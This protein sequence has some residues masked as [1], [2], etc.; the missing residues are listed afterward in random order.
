MDPRIGILVRGGKPVYYAF[1]HGHGS[2]PFEG[3]LDAVESALG[4]KPTRKPA[5]HHQ[6]VEPT[7]KP[8]AEPQLW[9]VTLRFQYPA[10]DEVGGIV[11]RGIVARSKS[12]ANRIAANRAHGDGHTCGG[13]GRYFFRAEKAQD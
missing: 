1:T 8:Q 5:E 2:E 9:N 12:E 6:I 7:R 4:L 3:D 10:W 11:Y 13:S